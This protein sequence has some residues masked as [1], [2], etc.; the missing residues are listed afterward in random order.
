MKHH[1]LTEADAEVITRYYCYD[2][3]MKVNQ[4]RKVSCSVSYLQE[5]VV[6]PASN[7]EL[8]G[9]NHYDLSTTSFPLSLDY[10]HERQSVVFTKII[11]AGVTL[12][13]EMLVK[14]ILDPKERHKQIAELLAFKVEE[15]TVLSLSFR[16]VIRSSKYAE[17]LRD[18]KV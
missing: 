15:D 14:G 1:N 4:D 10:H 18:F 3:I 2:H 9:V 13:M 17:F 8:V 12:E 7:L 16:F 6:D 11:N 5:T